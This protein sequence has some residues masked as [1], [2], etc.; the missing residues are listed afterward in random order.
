V[1]PETDDS[2]RFPHERLQFGE[3]GVVLFLRRCQTAV[4]GRH[5]PGEES[6]LKI[7]AAVL[8]AVP[9][10]SGP[11]FVLSLIRYLDPIL[12]GEIFTVQDRRDLC[13]LHAMVFPH[14]MRECL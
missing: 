11:R 13:G 4:A 3:H 8:F 14:R 6:I 7:T 5:I 12:K 10:N 1:P 9:Q 2:G